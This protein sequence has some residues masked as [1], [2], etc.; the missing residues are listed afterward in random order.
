MKQGERKKSSKV[1]VDFNYE[2]ALK[3]GEFSTK[4]LWDPGSENCEKSYI[5]PWGPG[6]VSLLCFDF[7]KV[8]SLFLGQIY[9]QE[10]PAKAAIE[11]FLRLNDI[12]PLGE[13]LIVCVDHESTGE[14]H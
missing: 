11:N 6:K 14:T 9:G 12:T 8:N 3:M 7:G 10:D 5:V 4:V 13:E 2:K 1:A